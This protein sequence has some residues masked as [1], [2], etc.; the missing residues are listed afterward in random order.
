M[1][2]LTHSIKRL[3]DLLYVY[4]ALW[5]IGQFLTWAQNFVGN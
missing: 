2:N 5:G 1:D 3:I 4:A